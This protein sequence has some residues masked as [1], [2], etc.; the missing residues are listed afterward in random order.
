MR[1]DYKLMA[2]LAT[3]TRLTPD[4]RIERLLH[5]NKRL[6]DEPTV[7]EEFRQWN[8]KLD[9]KLVEIPARVITSENIIFGNMK[10]SAT[11]T[12]DWTRHFRSARLIVCTKL[13]DW[14][15]IVP[16][17]AR[18]DAKVRFNVFLLYYTFFF[19]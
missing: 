1:T 13:S 6:Q 5:F 11:Q 16:E 2:K 4:R 15:L 17:R 12:A 3:F 7:V 19:F 14:I 8:L 9:T 10:Q 18:L